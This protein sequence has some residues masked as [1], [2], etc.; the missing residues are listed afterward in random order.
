MPKENENDYDTIKRE[1]QFKAD[2][3]GLYYRIEKSMFGEWVCHAVP[4]PKNQH[5]RDLVGELV[6][7]STYVESHYARP[8]L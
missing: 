5:G 1:A 3:H 8:W 4:W 6:S 7:P 2:K